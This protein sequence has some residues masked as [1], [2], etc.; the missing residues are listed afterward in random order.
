MKYFY[1]NGSP[2]AGSYA[3]VTIAISQ[4]LSRFVKERL[5]AINLLIGDKPVKISIHEVVGEKKINLRNLVSQLDKLKE[6]FNPNWRRA[7]EQLLFQRICDCT[8]YNSQLYDCRLFADSHVIIGTG[9][10]KYAFDDC[11]KRYFSLQDTKI[12]LE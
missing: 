8:T 5:T 10:E 1:D 9:D 7:R 12:S 2:G 11:F 4:K 6:I 3:D